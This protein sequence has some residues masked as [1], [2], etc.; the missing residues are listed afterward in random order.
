MTGAINEWVVYSPPKS[1]SFGHQT[2]VRDP[3][4]AWPTVEQFLMGLEQRQWGF[5]SRL[6]CNGPLAATRIQEARLVFGPEMGPS[7]CY[8]DWNIAESQRDLGLRFVFDDDKFPKQDIGP[9]SFSFS[10]RFLWPEFEQFPYW[11]AEGERRDPRS[12]LGVIVGGGRL[13]LQPNFIF[14]APWNS[15]VLKNFLARLELISPFRFRDQYFQRLLPVKK[16]PVGRSLR[17]PKNWRQ[18]VVALVH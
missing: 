11:K 9:S 5:H 17:L 6:T 2:R 8:A 4:K 15:E 13:F 3:R 10:Y 7:E 1:V 14:P 12:S 16:G 18:T